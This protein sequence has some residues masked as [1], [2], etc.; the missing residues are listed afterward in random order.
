MNVR[1]NLTRFRFAHVDTRLAKLP[2]TLAMCKPQGAFSTLLSD[3]WQQ[4][5]DSG[6]SYAP[7][8]RRRIE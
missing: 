1:H 7:L 6:S 8:C 5:V 2:T 4:V 3:V